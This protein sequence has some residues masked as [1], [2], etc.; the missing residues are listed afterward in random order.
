MPVAVGDARLDPQLEGRQSAR[1]PTS[2]I[3]M[4]VIKAKMAEASAARTPQ[5]G[6]YSGIWKYNETAIQER[7][8]IISARVVNWKTRNEFRGD[9]SR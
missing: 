2:S 5:R 9:P 7:H 6:S 3:H 4:K 1:I 8:T